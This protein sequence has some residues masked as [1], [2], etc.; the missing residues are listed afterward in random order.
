LKQWSDNDDKVTVYGVT[1]KDVEHFQ[2]L[3]YRRNCERRVMIRPTETFKDINWS[4]DFITKVPTIDDAPII[5]K[6]FFECCSGGIDYE[7]FGSK[8][9]EEA[10]V[11]AER[12]LKMYSSNNTLEGSTLVFDKNTNQLVGACIAGINGFCDNDF[13]EIGEIVVRQDY[14]RLGLASKMIKTALTNLKKISPA[15]ILCVTIGN[16]AEGLYDNLGFFS[17]VK[18]TGMD[19]NK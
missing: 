7:T 9:L 17:G 12:T 2:K 18:F 3:G 4:D 5:G 19:Y 8:M 14:R 11:D 16:P 13:S 1:P 10:I 15:T 6:L